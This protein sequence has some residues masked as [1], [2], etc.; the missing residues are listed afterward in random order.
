MNVVGQFLIIIKTTNLTISS[1]SLA[2]V[3]EIFNS[4]PEIVHDKSLSCDLFLLLLD[5]R[6]HLL[7]LFLGRSDK[8]TTRQVR[9]NGK[10]TELF[11]QNGK[12]LNL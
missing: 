8:I 11:S 5:R 4:I 2:V 9:A 3:L 10:Q 1:I 7:I 6:L 12:I